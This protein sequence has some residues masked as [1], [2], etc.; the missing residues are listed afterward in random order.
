MKYYSVL[1]KENLN[2]KGEWGK[3]HF[4]YNINRCYTTQVKGEE[5]DYGW[6]FSQEDS[7]Y[8]AHQVYFLESQLKCNYFKELCK[9]CAH[10]KKPALMVKLM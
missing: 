3:L 1:G 9:E 2:P 4:I 8:D 6:W 7:T 5:D 10:K